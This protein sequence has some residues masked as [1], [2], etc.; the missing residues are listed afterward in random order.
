MG[1]ERSAPV[2]P[3]PIAGCRRRPDDEHGVARASSRLRETLPK[4]AMDVAVADHVFVGRPK[5]QGTG[6]GR[7]LRERQLR[8]QWSRSLTRPVASRLRGAQNIDECRKL[9]IDG[10][11]RCRALGARNP[12]LG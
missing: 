11:Y 12:E 2:R 6:R 1:S 5:R 4:P 9:A 7:V 10:R 8:E 3:I